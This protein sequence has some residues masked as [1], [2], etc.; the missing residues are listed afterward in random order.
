M[1]NSLGLINE[2]HHWSRHIGGTFDQLIRSKT[3]LVKLDVNYAKQFPIISVILKRSNP[4]L[5]ASDSIGCA[6]FNN[7]FCIVDA[8][9]SILVHKL[10]TKIYVSMHNLLLKFK[11]LFWRKIANEIRIPQI[12]CHKTIKDLNK[13]ISYF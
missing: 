2:P 1:P 3:H 13:K 11:K 7:I 8:Q 4:Q 9:W 12:R 6:N 10:S 5:A